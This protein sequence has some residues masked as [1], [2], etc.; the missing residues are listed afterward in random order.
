M[1]FA[2]MKY[3]GRQHQNVMCDVLYHCHQRKK[4][5]NSLST[6][7][8]K[9]ILFLFAKSSRKVLKQQMY[10]MLLFIE[11]HCGIGHNYPKSKSIVGLAS[12]QAKFIGF[13][14]QRCFGELLT[15]IKFW[16]F[17][18]IE[19]FPS[20]AK[21]GTRRVVEYYTDIAAW[22]LLSSLAIGLTWFED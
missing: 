21:Y 6:A 3:L 16:R 5:L 8:G 18:K 10:E 12:N 14:T 15:L 17:L 11:D 4:S 13:G 1:K 2:H 22:N 7:S 20:C 9:G 19:M